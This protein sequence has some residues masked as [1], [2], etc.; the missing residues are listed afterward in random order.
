MLA[1]GTSRMGDFPESGYPLVGSKIL[2]MYF[3]LLE[4]LS[5][6]GDPVACRD[7]DRGV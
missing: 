5:L 1:A 2:Q 7:A 3:C 4:N 6:F